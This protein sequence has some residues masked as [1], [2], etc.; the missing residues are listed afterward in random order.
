MIKQDTSVS[1]YVTIEMQ[2]IVR[3]AAEPREPSDSVK[4]AIRRAA[5]R[6]GLS[7]RRATTFWYGRSCAVRATE[8]DR[9]READLRLLK[10]RGRRIESELNG[11]RASIAAREGYVAALDQP[12]TGVVGD[13]DRWALGAAGKVAG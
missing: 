3:R 6:L 10:E 4:A 11:I 8:A 5:R 13:L 7:H 1:N 2:G 12:A 9:L